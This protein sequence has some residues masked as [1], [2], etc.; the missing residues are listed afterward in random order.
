[1]SEKKPSL[2]AFSAECE[3]ISPPN[4]SSKLEYE[5]AHDEA[6][7]LQVFARREMSRILVPEDKKSS[8]D[9]DWI[10][11]VTEPTPY[12]SI[13]NGETAYEFL[14]TK[15]RPLKTG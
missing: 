12:K 6:F 8:V 2:S 11:F 13:K 15:I 1:M 7:G 4:R 3:A 10:L 5:D 14:K 9:F